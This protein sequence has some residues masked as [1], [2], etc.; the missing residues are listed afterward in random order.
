MRIP[1]VLELLPTLQLYG[2]PTRMIRTVFGRQSRALGPPKARHPA[3]NAPD[4]V[5]GKCRRKMHNPGN[6]HHDS[7]TTKKIIDE[8]L[9][10][11]ALSSL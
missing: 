6:D 5:W 11:I 2:S 1:A 8:P 4:F 10:D 7:R 9:T 3:K